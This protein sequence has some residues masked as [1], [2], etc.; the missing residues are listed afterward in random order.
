MIGKN[1]HQNSQVCLNSTGFTNGN[2]HVMLNV[3]NKLNAM[4]SEEISALEHLVL[5]CYP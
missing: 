5:Q 4:H 3:L 2:I 1:A